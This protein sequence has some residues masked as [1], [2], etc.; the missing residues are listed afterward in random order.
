MAAT[1]TVPGRPTPLA[2][3]AHDTTVTAGLAGAVVSALVSAGIIAT[4]RGNLISALL[5][6]IPGVITIATAAYTANHV[7]TKGAEH[8]TPL[9]SPMDNWERKLVPAPAARN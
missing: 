6:L 7:A 2:D 8:V 3:L 5:G 4:T 9:S 1:P